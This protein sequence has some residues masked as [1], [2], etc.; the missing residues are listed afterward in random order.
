MGGLARNADQ[1]K[2]LKLTTLNPL[3]T[4]ELPNSKI[5]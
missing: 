1:P 5:Y 3:E 2:N 4:E